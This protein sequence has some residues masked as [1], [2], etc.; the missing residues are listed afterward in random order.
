MPN[1]IKYS[2]SQQTL[3]LK[4]GNFYIGTGDVGKGSTDNTDYYNGITPPSGGYTIYLNKASGGPS[5]YTA[6]NDSQLI[7]LTNSIAGTSYTTVN[8]CLTYFYTQTDKLCL[9]KD[10]ETIPT[11][12]LIMDFDAGFVG[13]YP[14]NGTSFKDVSSTQ[15]TG[16]LTNGPTYSSEGGG[17]IS[18]DGVNDY[19]NAPSSF[20][21]TPVPVWSYSHWVKLPS[22][23]KDSTTVENGNTPN[24]CG[25][26]CW[27]NMTYTGT[28]FGVTFRA[29]QFVVGT[30]YYSYSMCPS[31]AS[32]TTY[33]NTWVNIG[34]VHRTGNP[35]NIKCYI[36]GVLDRSFNSP[37]SNDSA[38]NQLFTFAT[39]SDGY[40][41]GK[42]GTFQLWNRELS[43]TE[44]SNIFN[45]QKSRYGL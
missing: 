23:L 45:S 16:T 11:N 32:V 14:R 34:C 20:T 21:S 36:N 6:A 39:G 5:I 7:S 43:A 25:P 22:V 44:F 18:F 40:F 33:S 38:L 35:N 9:S 12:G 41:N 42:I 15:M 19:I 10:Y 29:N 4:K 2:T 8:E 37:G 24:A 13:S 17:S 31:N 30:N 1:T 26:Y 28:A 3:A 27:I